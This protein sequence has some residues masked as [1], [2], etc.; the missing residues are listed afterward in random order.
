MTEH[1]RKHII[2]KDDEAEMELASFSTGA[3]RRP[4]AIYSSN[5]PQ[6]SMSSSST[7]SIWT[8]ARVGAVGGGKGGAVVDEGGPDDDGCDSE[9]ERVSEEAV[10]V[11]S[12]HRTVEAGAKHWCTLPSTRLTR[13]RRRDIGERENAS[14]CCFST[15]RR[16]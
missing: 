11:F 1:A 10:A 16:K 15:T 14:K 8:W 12:W 13:S 7:I 4:Q 9:S 6:S 2:R 3:R 5:A